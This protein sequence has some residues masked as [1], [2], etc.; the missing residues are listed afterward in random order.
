MVGPAASASRKAAT[1]AQ[2]SLFVTNNLETNT[3]TPNQKNIDCDRV[4]PL[5]MSAMN[6]K[7]STLAPNALACEYSKQCGVPWTSMCPS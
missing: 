7:D 1:D 6:L 4:F 3:P 5:H 2:T